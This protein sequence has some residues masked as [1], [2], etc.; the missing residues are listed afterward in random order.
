MD[1]KMQSSFIPKTPISV[2]RGSHTSSSVNLFFLISVLVFIFSLAVGAFFF[3]YNANQQKQ[4]DALSASLIASGKKDFSDTDV[5]AWTEL[6]KR[7][8][9]ASELLQ[10][11]Y[12]VSSLFRLLQ[13]L[14]VKN[15]RFTRFDFT[16][17]D[18]GVEKTSLALGLSGEGRSYNAVSYQSDVMKA[19]ESLEDALFSN[20][21]L[22]EKGSILFSMKASVDPALTSY[23]NLF[24]TQ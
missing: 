20:I 19:S 17:K 8:Q 14:T 11:H 5:N 12:A 3:F 7:T 10:R 1:P 13:E 2:D 15:V 18:D 21:R 4:I 9:A 24:T 23:K 6:D 22:D 16:V